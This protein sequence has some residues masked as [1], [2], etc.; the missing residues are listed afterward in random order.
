MGA[1]ESK[2]EPAAEP[3]PKFMTNPEVADALPL[4]A[5]SDEQIVAISRQLAHHEAHAGPASPSTAAYA[6]ALAARAAPP[7]G[8]KVPRVRFGKTE[9]QMPILTCGGMRVQQ[10][11]IPDHLL[12][13][14]PTLGLSIGYH[15]MS[16][17]DP[18][19]QARRRAVDIF[20]RLCSGGGVPSSWGMP[21]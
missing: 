9:L 14:F 18:T 2:P 12:P 10:S 17:I 4:H 1:S 7:P 19:V 8:Y 3:D 6:R 21:R 16:D 13:R 20:P 15:E 5:L 11:A